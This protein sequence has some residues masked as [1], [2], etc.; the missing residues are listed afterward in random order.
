[1]NDFYHVEDLKKYFPIRRGVLS[2]EVG[3]VKAVDGISFDI[4]EGETL[5]IAGESGCG[6]TTLGRCL[7]GV[8]PVTSGNLFFMGQNINTMRKREFNN[9]RLNMGMIF[10]DPYSSLNPRMTVGDIVGEP[11]LNFNIARGSEKDKMV[12]ELLTKVG[13]SKRH[14]YRYPHE[15]SGGQKQRIGIARALAV[16]PKLIIADEPVAALDVSVRATILNLMRDLQTEFNLT[17][18]FISHDLSVVKHICDRVMI[19][20]LGKIVEIAETD[21][22]Y[23]RPEHPYTKALMSAIPIPDPT[24]KKERIILPG[25]VPTPV[26]LPKGCRF[27]PRCLEAKQECHEKEPELIEVREGHYVACHD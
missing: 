24:S 19:M 18:V 16:H 5:G 25:D 1:M 2:H 8:L 20:Y 11:L 13:L 9:I 10:Q 27:H 21:E 22:L 15:F 23:S 26:N 4:R 7:I 17:Y 12:A 3:Q 14:I 6:K